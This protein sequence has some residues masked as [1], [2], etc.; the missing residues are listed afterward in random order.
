MEISRAAGAFQE[1][2]D[3]D[4]S[5]VGDYR[6]VGL[7]GS[8]GMGKVYLSYTPAGR[9]VAIKVI[10]PEF[11]ED[12]EFRRRFADEVAAARRVQGLCTAP[13]LDSDTEGPRPWLATAYVPGPT[14]SSAVATYGPLPVP[15]VLLLVAGIAEALQAIH[16]AGLVHRDLKPGNVLL[17]SDGPRVID[18]GIA[19][20]ADAT[21]LTASGVTVGT[22]AFMAPEQASGAEVTAATDV[23]ALGQLAAFAA[24]GTSAYGNG[25]SHALL[26]RIVHQ[27]PDLSGVPA[28]LRDLVT[29]CLTKDPG[30]RPALTEVIDLCRTAG[31]H[32][33]LQRTESWLPAGGTAGIAQEPTAPAPGTALTAPL[34][35]VVPPSPPAPPPPRPTPPPAPLPTSPAPPR[36][37]PA[38][39]P[40]SYVSRPS[41]Y[42]PAPRRKRTARTALFATL[43][44]L[45]LAATAL[46]GY[47]LTNGTGGA[48]DGTVSADATSSPQVGSRKVALPSGRYLE[49]A[50]VSLTPR[51]G[52]EDDIY[53]LCVEFE[54]CK[55][56]ASHAQLAQLESGEQ[57]TREICRKKRDFTAAINTDT[58]MAGSQI[59]VRNQD[60]YAAL[61]TIKNM[62][63]TDHRDASVVFY[64]DV[65]RDSH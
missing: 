23:F 31:D 10:R 57:G 25:P 55:F 29:R 5:A 1:L 28:E 2:E 16:G 48:G 56:G 59:C 18:F 45:V 13:V 44:V 11:A 9:P 37:S 24:T 43:A 36:P 22:P 27:D 60:G 47:V 52:S 33:Q 35:A 53:F 46:G 20:A 19:R 14:L 39:P 7:L 8:G 64:A 58:L 42:I 62:P 54:G 30:Q 32:T 26:Y 41:S 12:P 21:A 49:L 50:D 17:A 38:P 51:E 6:L 61:I 34:T 15:T 65:W 40:S 63:V 3:D 4:P